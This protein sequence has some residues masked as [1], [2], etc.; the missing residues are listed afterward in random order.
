MTVPGVLNVLF[1]Y[2]DENK[3]RYIENL[4]EAV[5]IR[6]ISSLEEWRDETIK[7]VNWTADRLRKLGF[8][9]SL[10]NIGMQVLSNG[11]KLQLPPVLLAT[12]GNDPKKKT[13][14]IYGHL[15]VQ[16]ATIG[17]GWDTDPFELVE[18]NG[19]VY[20]RG[21]ADDKGPVLSCL[22]AVEAF[23]KINA[24]LP[25]NVKF[26]FEAMEESGSIGLGELIAREKDR[27]FQN[28]DYI[29]VCDGSSL[30][31]D[32]PCIVYG[33][34][35]F[36]FFYL[37]VECASQDLHSGIHGGAV[38]E[39][40]TDLVYLLDSLVD[41]DGKLLITDIYKDV[42]PLQPEEETIYAKID[43]NV[44][45]YS[46]TVNA[47]KLLHNDKVKLLLNT[48]RYPSLSIHG[49]EGAHSES[50]EKSVIPAKVTGKFSI[51]LVE[52][53][54]VEDV[55]ASVIKYLHKKLEERGRATKIKVSIGGSGA[56]W[57]ENP[58]HPHY[59]AAMRA[60]TS[61]YKIDADLIRAGGSMSVITTLQQITGK[62][63]IN[64]ALSSGDDNTHSQ[65]EKMN[66]ENYMNG[67]KVIAAY[68]YEVSQLNK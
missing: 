39:A 33:L 47:T 37:T 28:V 26:I 62:N 34:R 32:V 45:D 17:D 59:S 61:V 46:R 22:H 31:K 60:I 19:K 11:T 29:C 16:Q 68:L 24:D 30:G 20:G 43:F 6:S 42:I 12:L 40:M 3:S 7:M 49:I 2:V 9:V 41:K 63:I 27:F 36:C 66:I 56:A 51:R 21:S 38:C 55:Q 1:K 57:K 5:A 65:N 58:N 67:T 14:C 25:V 64:L 15:D 54:K 18:R 44:E 50:G 23:Q 8:Q 4:R 35:G 53:Q 13:V 52:N 48:W 10:E